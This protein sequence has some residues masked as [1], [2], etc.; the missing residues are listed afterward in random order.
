MAYGLYI[1][2]DLSAGL[3]LEIH[4]K[5]WTGAATEIRAMGTTPLSLVGLDNRGSNVLTP[6]IKS[7][8]NIDIK[9][10]G[11][12]DFQELFTSYATRYKVL[13]FRNGVQVWGGY[14]TPDSYSQDLEYRTSINLVA[15]D[16][17]GQLD[18]LDFDYFNED[19]DGMVKVAD[20]I[21]KAQEKIEWVMAPI[22]WY[23]QQ[24]V[25]S[26]GTS[27]K[28]SYI[29]ARLF[30]TDGNEDAQTWWEVLETVLSSLGQQMRYVGDNKVYIINVADLYEIGNINGSTAFDYSIGGAAGMEITPSWRQLTVKQDFG[31]I[32]NAIDYEQDEDYFKYIA[33][34]VG[35]MNR[36][37][38]RNKFFRYNTADGTT[39]GTIEGSWD[40]GNV[41]GILQYDGPM[42]YSNLSFDN[43]KESGT[44]YYN[45]FLFE[46]YRSAANTYAYL[47][48]KVNAGN[49]FIFQAS[50]F[51]SVFDVDISDSNGETIHNLIPIEATSGVTVRFSV[52]LVGSNGKALYLHDAGW[53][54]GENIISFS[55][56]GAAGS[57]ETVQVTVNILN[58]PD[59]GELQICFYPPQWSISGEAAGTLRT[60][61]VVMKDL[62]F[63]TADYEDMSKAPGEMEIVGVANEDGNT[64]EN[65]DI[66][67]GEVPSGSGDGF[68]YAGGLFDAS[69][70][71]K[72]LTGWH[73]S[74][75]KGGV[76]HLSELIGRGFAH[77][78]CAFRNVNGEKTGGKVLTGTVPFPETA[79]FS[80]HFTIDDEV[81]IVNAATMDMLAQTAEVE[82][83]QVLPYVHQSSIY[84]ANEISG[85]GSSSIGG[86]SSTTISWGTPREAVRL[87]E[88]PTATADEAK[89]SYLLLDKDGDDT[90]HKYPASE[91]LKL[92]D[93]FFFDEKNQAVGTKY[94]LYTDKT[95]SQLGPAGSGGEG[96]GGATTLGGL[97]NVGAWADIAGA[98]DVVL[99]RAAGSDTWGAK[100]L[101][102]IVGLDTDALAEYLT[103]NNYATHS[104]VAEAVASGVAGK[105][106]ASVFDNHVSD[107]SL[108]KTAGERAVLALLSVDD[109]G[110]LR[111]SG[112][113]YTE[114]WI[115]QK[116]PGSDTGGGGSGGGTYYHDQLEH[117]DYPDQ[118]PIAAVTGLQAA[119]DAKLNA[120]SIPSWALQPSKPSYA[121]DEITGKPT[122]LAGYGI[123]DAMT[124]EAI[125]KAM[126]QKL[127]N[128]YT[129]KSYTADGLFG[130]TASPAVITGWAGTGRILFGYRD[131][132]NGDYCPNIGFQQTHD[133]VNSPLITTTKLSLGLNRAGQ[134][135]CSGTLVVEGNIVVNGTITQL[136]G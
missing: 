2:K 52:R 43:A 96:G 17:L 94:P 74:D 107:T 16:N 49:S 79:Y 68:T 40:N 25:A 56:A 88:L 66:T 50:V 33:L 97:S 110:N 31:L 3:R 34:E 24:Y 48:F 39:A 47:P 134:L 93:W 57:T 9:D 4:R 103:Q 100:K 44:T 114:G 42:F 28:D 109:D 116:G 121:W 36:S 83:R 136:G 21:T 11:E 23:A 122:T 55:P 76:L 71:R 14:L 62:I 53:F 26:D 32:D 7:T 123:T 101:A 10:L 90:A 15:R 106:D 41:T 5:D 86:G 27:V 38:Y 102:D 105:L 30:K 63:H 59:A 112:N 108:H 78:F 18:Q 8:L 87:Y 124:T 46:S 111:A 45:T 69:I 51:R 82:L 12:I 130:E 119:L 92:T 58:I 133:P 125:I 64:K 65:V 19:G 120:A 129:F 35:P 131:Y 132:G 99:F 126:D 81:Y 80:K 67:V 22:E 115:S 91:L 54:S 72:A 104:Y 29:N 95:L 13:V 61:M 128:Y 1:Y 117:L 135:V 98:D 77:H 113:F 84:E 89:K 85:G 75:N 127:Q 118:H 20:L 6:I 73:R 70:G 37:L 60:A